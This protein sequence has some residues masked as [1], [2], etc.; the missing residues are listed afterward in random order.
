MLIGFV[1]GAYSSICVDT[2]LWV[3]WKNRS[4]RRRGPGAVN[5]DAEETEVVEV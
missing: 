2:S 5:R 1:S 3:V 4:D